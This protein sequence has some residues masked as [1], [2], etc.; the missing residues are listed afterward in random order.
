MERSMLSFKRHD[1]KSAEEETMESRRASSTSVRVSKSSSRV[2][3]SKD[4]RNS[5]CYLATE[6]LQ[7][8]RPATAKSST[9][10]FSK[11]FLKC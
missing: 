7:L 5:E 10:P 3:R 9:K 2:D 11:T 4:P 8:S 6:S 1:E